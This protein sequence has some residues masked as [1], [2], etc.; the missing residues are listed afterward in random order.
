MSVPGAMVVIMFT[1]KQSGLKK[2]DK[3]QSVGKRILH[4]DY[5][6]DRTLGK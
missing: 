5:F 1:L 6:D 2:A 3:N 4:I